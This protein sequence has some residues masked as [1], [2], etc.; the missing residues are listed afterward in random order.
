MGYLTLPSPPSPSPWTFAIP[1]PLVCVK[2]MVLVVSSGE[3]L[4]CELSC[5]CGV[6][7]SEEAARLAEQIATLSVKHNGAVNFAG[8]QV[9]HKT[10]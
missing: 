7:T 3:S 10:H 6:D 8:I 1:V 4:L 2:A 5:R 9:S